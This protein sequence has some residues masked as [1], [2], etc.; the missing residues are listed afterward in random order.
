M[1]IAMHVRNFSTLLGCYFCYAKGMHFADG[2]PTSWPPKYFTAPLRTDALWEKFCTM[3]EESPVNRDILGHKARCI[4]EEIPGFLHS[5]SMS[6]EPMH[7]CFMGVF[8][9]V[10][11]KCVLDDKRNWRY[12]TWEL[13]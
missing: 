1:H 11:N 9:D 5:R 2:P 6:L 3:M 13:I 12:R 8:K 10:M 4:L 7:N